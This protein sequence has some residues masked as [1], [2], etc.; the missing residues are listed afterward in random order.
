MASANRARQAFGT[1]PHGDAPPTVQA[2][3]PWPHTGSL[4]RVLVVSEIRLFQDA[5]AALLGRQAGVCV[6]GATNRCRRRRKPLSYVPTS[7]CSMRRDPAISATQELSR[8]RYRLRKSWRSVLPR[9]TPKSSPWRPPASRDT[10][11][12]MPRRK[13]W[14]P[15][16]RARCATNSCAR[17][18]LRQRSVTMSRSCRGM[19]AAVRRRNL[20]PPRSRSASCRSAI[21]ST[22]AYPTSRS[23]GNWG[24]GDH[25]EEPRPQHLRQA[26]GPSPRRGRRPSQDGP[27]A[28]APAASGARASR[29]GG[30]SARRGLMIRPAQRPQLPICGQINLLPASA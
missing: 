9:P 8:I 18:V 11:V 19:A 21:S 5:F 17:R 3:A 13:M 1:K 15:F 6:V 12:M 4:L 30:H 25:G 2:T 28:N 14:S 27:A 23:R 20:L 29:R 10:C 22:A 16:S 26:Q 24:S 7:C